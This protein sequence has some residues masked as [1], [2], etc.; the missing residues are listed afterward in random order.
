LLAVLILAVSVILRTDH[1]QKIDE[2]SL[3]NSSTNFSHFPA[4]NTT[5]KTP[6]GPVSIPLEKPPFINQ[7][8]KTHE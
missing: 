5:N 8:E 6:S 7:E 1:S 4:S 2:T 3:N